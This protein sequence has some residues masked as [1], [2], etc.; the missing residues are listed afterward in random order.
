MRCLIS[1]GLIST[2]QKETCNWRKFC[3]DG[4]VG[5]WLIGWEGWS[6]RWNEMS[7]QPGADIPMTTFG[8]I[9]YIRLVQKWRLSIP[10]GYLPA[11][12]QVSSAKKRISRWQVGTLGFVIILC[13]PS[14]QYRGFPGELGLDMTKKRL[15]EIIFIKLQPGHYLPVFNL[16]W[17]LFE[18][19]AWNTKG[20]HRT[21]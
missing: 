5:S 7:H 14:H 16:K 18:R 17:K 11:G 15:Y 19:G 20:S 13:A 10:G 21:E 4:H 2:W 6:G 8:K 3:V 9:L 1:P 12:R